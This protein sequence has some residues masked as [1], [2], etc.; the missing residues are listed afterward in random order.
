MFTLNG[1]TYNTEA[2]YIK[3]RNELIKQAMVVHSN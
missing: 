2:E 1:K 3:A